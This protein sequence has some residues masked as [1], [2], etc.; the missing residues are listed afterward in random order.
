MGMLSAKTQPEPVR[1]SSGQRQPEVL[2]DCDALKLGLN[3]GGVAISQI[4]QSVWEMRKG[5]SRN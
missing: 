5:S 3:S 2:V 1:S 4:G